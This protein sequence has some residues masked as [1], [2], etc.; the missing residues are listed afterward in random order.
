MYAV[1]LS[2]EDKLSSIVTAAP[3]YAVSSALDKN[4]RRL[5]YGIMTSTKISS[6][7]GRAAT[8]HLLN[9]LKKQRYDLPAGIEFVPSDWQRVRS[10]GEY[11]LTQCRATLKKFLKAS[12]PDT[13]ASTH[14]NIFTLGQR[15][16]KDTGTVLT[17]ELCARIALMRAQFIL[18]P[19]DD[20][21][22]ELDKQLTW[23]RE[24][25]QFDEHKTAK[26]F[27]IVLKED[28]EKHGKSEEYKLPKDAIVDTWQLTVDDSIA[29]DGAAV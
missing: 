26:A 12:M 17:V 1:S 25:A 19:G 4:M 7:K 22:D 2:I 15:F 14:A 20:F 24:Q 18:Y 6:Y 8:A 13:G 11:Q 3:E 23:M 28:R 21:W 10:R 16:V 5:S 9:M 27:K 29:A